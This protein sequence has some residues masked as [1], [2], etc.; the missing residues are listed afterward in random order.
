MINSAKSK[1]CGWRPHEYLKEMKKCNIHVEITNLVV[2][3][4][5]DSIDRI[6]ELA[7]WVRENLGKETPFHLLRFHPNY[8]LTEFPS[9]PIKTLE[10]ACETA[11]STGL[12]YVYIGNVPGHRYEN[13]YCPNCNTLLIKR[14]SFEIV[15]WHL[16]K[17]MRCPECGQNI[18]IKGQFHPSGFS[19]PY[20][21][22]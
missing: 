20:A 10:R 5:G 16:T 18:A 2:P 1:H 17:D 22:I 6:H 14:F 13:T 8:R 15:K 9:T 4:I 11:R 19:Y 7:L 3:K 21:L 12:S